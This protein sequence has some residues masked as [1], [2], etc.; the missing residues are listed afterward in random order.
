MHLQGPTGFGQ[1]RIISK[2]KGIRMENKKMEVISFKEVTVY[3]AVF[4]VFDD[5]L[6]SH[7]Q[8]SIFFDKN[9][10]EIGSLNYLPERNKANFPAECSADK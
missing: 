9:G 4:D 5:F 3:E 6:K 8:V 2:K 1:N 10:N 7:K